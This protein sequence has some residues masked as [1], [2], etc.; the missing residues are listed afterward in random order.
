MEVNSPEVNRFNETA[1]QQAL[2]ELKWLDVRPTPIEERL[3]MTENLR[4]NSS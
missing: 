1:P 4:K 2:D 3:T